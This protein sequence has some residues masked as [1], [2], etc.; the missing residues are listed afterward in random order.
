MLEK[1]TP[2][3]R[4][5][6][7]DFIIELDKIKSSSTSFAIPLDPHL[8]CNAFS[9]RNALTELHMAVLLLFLSGLKR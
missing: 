5:T 3:M 9:N 4:S 1:N 2:C 7:S 8:L 6:P